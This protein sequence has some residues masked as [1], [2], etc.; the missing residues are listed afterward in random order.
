MVAFSLIGQ[1][2]I[3]HRLDSGSE[4]NREVHVSFYEELEVK[5]LW[6]TL[7]YGCYSYKRSHWISKNK[8]CT[9]NF[10]ANHEDE[11]KVCEDFTDDEWKE[12]PCIKKANHLGY[13]RK[14]KD[15]NTPI[16]L[17]TCQSKLKNFRAQKVVD[18]FNFILPKFS[19]YNVA[20]R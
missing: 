1:Q 15:S 17:F 20:S 12:T 8:N 18:D 13:I 10:D 16:Q 7:L 2:D 14:T 5:S 4:M 11:N 3:A 19:I 9:T 6:F